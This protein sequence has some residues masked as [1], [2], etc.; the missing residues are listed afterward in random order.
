MSVFSSS[1]LS[2]QPQDL[3]SLL[4]GKEEVRLGKLAKIPQGG[5]AQRLLQPVGQTLI[6]TFGFCSHLMGQIIEH[7]IKQQVQVLISP[8]PLESP[9][10][11]VQD[12]PALEN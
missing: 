8:S 11:L 10:K 1:G 7:R 5:R 9:G 12:F 2:W 4:Q 6:C 3:G